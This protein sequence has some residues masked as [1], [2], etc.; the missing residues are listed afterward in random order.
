MMT[1]LMSKDVLYEPLKELHEKFPLYLK[2]NAAKLEPKDKER[3]EAQQK[4]VAEIIT[5][6][7]DPTYTPE[8]QEKG[9][10]IVTLMN[11]V[12]VI[13]A[14]AITISAH[15][16]VDAKSWIASGR[17]NGPTSARYGPWT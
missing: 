13:C 14:P 7:E 5:I 15:L 17:N 16:S 3:Y 10:K 1:Q 2:D 9:V 12:R 6:F 4:I 11:T 8:D